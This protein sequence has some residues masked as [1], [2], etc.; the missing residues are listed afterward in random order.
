MVVIVY[1]EQGHGVDAAGV[2]QVVFAEFAK[3]R[4]TR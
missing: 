2:A 3:S 1:L 4:M